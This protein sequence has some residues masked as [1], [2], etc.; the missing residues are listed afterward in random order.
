MGGP[1]LPRRVAPDR[2]VG[3]GGLPEPLPRG[4]RLVV[5]ATVSVGLLMAAIDQTVVATALFAIQRDLH[6]SLAWSSWTIT[7]YALGQIVMMPIAGR[8]SDQLG[9]RNLYLAATALFTLS[10]L[11]CALSTNIEMLIVFRALQS[12]GGGA[13][14]PSASGVVSDAFGED[15]DR[16]LGLFTSIFP[17]GG[18]I[19]PALGGLLVTYASWQ[20]I[21]LVNV[22]IGLLL[23]LLIWRV[24][25]SGRPE[26]SGTVDAAG[27]L[28]LALTLL[29]LMGSASLQGESQAPIWIVL[30]MLAAAA[31]SGSAL[32]RHFRRHP[33][34]FVPPRLL[35]DR[36][37]ALINGLNVLI[38]AATLGFAAL[39]PIYAEQHFGLD[40]LRA[41]SLLTVRAVAM[42]VSAAICVMAI[43]RSGYRPPLMCGMLLM[44]FG[45]SA[46]VLHPGAADIYGW[47]SADSVLTGIGMGI[48]LP[49][50]NNA[51][52]HLAEEDIAA[53]AG[54]RGMF[55]QSGGI[56][57]VTSASILTAAGSDPSGHQ[58]VV[59]LTIG[60]MLL[61]TVPL[62]IF[63][64]ER[65]R[66]GCAA[67]A[68]VP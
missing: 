68:P 30:G 50:S 54:L 27:A 64:P 33:S 45:M 6:T 22:P 42:I 25:P 65:P 36:R 63:V 57:A 52:L 40:T 37:F 8:L 20:W 55:R 62:A 26:R 1:D 61:V 12:V 35:R 47:L 39:I 29:M 24:V 11:L 34:P 48:A 9:R 28:L 59:F 15:R 18:I 32:A 10:S 2:G 21:F 46:L 5:F 16:A 44:G 51:M 31:L 19:G 4:R 66:P 17:I 13:L 7:V 53:L 56:L 49:S 23:L 43:R 41:S 3:S 58:G 14:M 38:G 67:A 60:G